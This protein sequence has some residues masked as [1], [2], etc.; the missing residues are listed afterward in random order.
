MFG[1]TWEL[2]FGANNRFR[3]FYEVDAAEQMVF[4]LA[5]GV[6]D[7]EKLIVGGEEIEL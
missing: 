7:R 5:I 3:V 4:V 6:K 1:A 2:R